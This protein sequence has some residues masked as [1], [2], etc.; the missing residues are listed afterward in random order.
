M[1]QN[2]KIKWG[3]WNQYWEQYS[4]LEE[5]NEAYDH[6]EVV[7]NEI[8]SSTGRILLSSDMVGIQES[9]I[10]RIEVL[11]NPQHFNNNISRMAQV[12]IFD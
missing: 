5:L 8:E 12:S 11:S 2:R 1:M 6:L 3:K 4:D 10:N 9:L 7:F